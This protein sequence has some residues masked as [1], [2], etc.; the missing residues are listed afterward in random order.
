MFGPLSRDPFSALCPPRAPRPQRQSRRLEVHV[1]CY[2][3]KTA[4][5]TAFRMPTAER[6]KGLLIFFRKKYFFVLDAE[7]E[8]VAPR[9]H[10]TCVHL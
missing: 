1:Q 2:A 8:A 10:G 3:Y 4:R 7:M 6:I 9:L 5:E